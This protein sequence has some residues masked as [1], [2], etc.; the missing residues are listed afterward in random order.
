MA[1][2]K[3]NFDHDNPLRLLAVA[4]G[5]VH[6]VTGIAC[7]RGHLCNR[8][9]QTGRCVDCVNEDRLKFN[10][11]PQG[12]EHQ[13]RKDVMRHLRKTG[14]T[15]KPS[16]AWH[17]K[18]ALY[19]QLVEAGLP[20]DLSKSLYV[21]VNVAWEAYQELTSDDTPLARR[22]RK[23]AKREAEHSAKLHHDA[24]RAARKAEREADEVDRAPMRAR[25]AE[26][27]A[28]IRS[29]RA[30][31]LSLC[32]MRARVYNHGWT[33]QRACSTPV[34]QA[35]RWNGLA[36]AARAAGLAIGT[37]EQRIHT[38][39]WSREKALSTPVNALHDTGLSAEA[40]AAGINVSAVSSRLARGWTKEKAL[41]TPVDA[42]RVSPE[43][44]VRRDAARVEREAERER[45]RELKVK[46]ETARVA[47]RA[48]RHARQV[49]P[50]QM[51]KAS[52]IA[53]RRTARAV[54][55]FRRAEAVDLGMTTFE[56][57][58]P[59][60]HCQGTTFYTSA[61]TCQ[62]CVSHRSRRGYV[63]VKAK[64]KLTRSFMC[65]TGLNH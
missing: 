6:Y 17:R 27:K 36:A 57:P 61:A 62:T 9:A 42:W 48:A 7:V 24:M 32:T 8:Y 26:I 40:R 49:S 51:A 37:V 16:Q 2:G 47:R 30:M 56:N 29:G 65:D 55:N 18:L 52:A 4:G 64:N 63:P 23:A 44:R 43:E 10:C 12:K 46:L 25:R 33:W 50:E 34:E 1:R 39:G 28:L 5:R 11:T 58:V 15:R 53:N 35:F 3:V 21:R 19:E 31:G 59:C 38:L 20:A 60:K 45:A 41:T 22:Q 13:R 54:K 14:K